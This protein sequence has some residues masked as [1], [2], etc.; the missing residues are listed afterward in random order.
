MLAPVG[1]HLVG[2][3]G[4]TDPRSAVNWRHFLYEKQARIAQVFDN[5]LE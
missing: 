5:T 1:N 2:D 4:Q 3:R